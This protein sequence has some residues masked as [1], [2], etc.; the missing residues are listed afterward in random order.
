M[1]SLINLSTFNSLCLKEFIQDFDKLEKVKKNLTTAGKDINSTQFFDE[2]AKLNLTPDQE[3][4][5]AKY[6]G[7]LKIK[8]T[9]TSHDLSYHSIVTAFTSISNFLNLGLE[10]DKQALKEI[11][12][13]SILSFATLSD[14]CNFLR[15]FYMSDFLSALKSDLESILVLKISSFLGKLPSEIDEMPIF[16]KPLIDLYQKNPLLEALLKP[17]F[18]KLLTL[19]NTNI[20]YKSKR[21]FSELAAALNSYQQVE[22]EENPEVE[23]DFDEKVKRLPIKS[24]EQVKI[25]Q[26]PAIYETDPDSK[27]FYVRVVP[28]QVLSTSEIIVAKI[29][30]S[31]KESNLNNKEAGFL[32]SLSNFDSVVKCYGVIKDKSEKNRFRLTIFMEKAD[33]SLKEDNENWERKSKEYK[34]ANKAARELE[35]LDALRQI[36]KGMHALKQKRIWHRDIKPGN[37]LVF[38]IGDKRIYKLTDFN[39]SREY[40]VD[41]YG[42]TVKTKST[43]TAFTQKFAAP[44]ILS[45]DCKKYFKIKELNFNWSDVFSLGLTILDMI[46]N[47]GGLNSFSDFLE[48][49]IQMALKKSIS[50]NYLQ[51]CI[52]SMLIVNPDKRIK[53]DEL[54]M[55][56]F[57]SDITYKEIEDN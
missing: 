11:L 38:I 52:R 13:S 55:T 40:E 23:M 2:N 36:V 26:G 45:N 9:L 8:S 49:N 17:K 21:E 1:A 10:Q 46:S 47:C 22:A 20:E 54:H 18:D 56:L 31:K 5:I 19:Y 14:A 25:L 44:E 24:W 39:I 32:I 4:Q 27:S 42:C 53:L 33:F 15:F 28:V 37:V 50:D 34:I 48:G 16:L 12:L 57:P 29:T 41:D 7:L 3:S 30:E 6:I 51:N 35:L 43:K